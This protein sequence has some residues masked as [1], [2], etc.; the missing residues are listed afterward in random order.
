MSVP[1]FKPSPLAQQLTVILD[2]GAVGQPAG[3]L[4][5]AGQRKPNPRNPLYV[6][7]VMAEGHL[8]P[9]LARSMERDALTRGYAVHPG[10]Q[11]SYPPGTRLVP[12][13]PSDWPPNWVSEEPP[14]GALDMGYRVSRP[15]KTYA[16]LAFPGDREVFGHDRNV[17]PTGAATARVSARRP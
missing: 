17:S 14:G 1:T 7:T 8:P 11:T 12:H 15:P 10:G 13:G 4:V 6:S 16:R 5:Q 3:D 2:R 9:F